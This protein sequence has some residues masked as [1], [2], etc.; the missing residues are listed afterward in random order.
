MEFLFIKM[1]RGAGIIEGVNIQFGGVQWI[2]TVIPIG[3]F[4]E[5]T[6]VYKISEF[7]RE[8]Q[9]ERNIFSIHKDQ[10]EIYSQGFE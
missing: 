3:E 6:V 10:D 9:L 8:P 2:V 4:L 1:E 5:L 7:R